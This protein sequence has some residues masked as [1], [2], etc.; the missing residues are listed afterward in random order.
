MK[1]IRNVNGGASYEVNTLGLEVGDLHK[2]LLSY[3]NEMHEARATGNSQTIDHLEAFV[4]T[5]LDEFAAT[6]CNYTQNPR[7]LENKMRGGWNLARGNVEAAL[8]AE[9]TG[10]YYANTEK[11]ASDE[12]ETA[13]KRRQSVSASNIADQLWRLGRAKEGLS[14]AQLSVKLWS[15]N[16][17]NYLVLGITAYYAGYK[18]QANH[19]F[20]SLG[21]IADFKDE[22]DMVSKCM[23]FERELRTMT[24]LPAVK[25]IVEKMGG[26]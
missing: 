16:S 23:Q 1:E 26:E 3:F 4:P 15:S 12:D 17:I 13:T 18:N 20:S 10:Y 2:R 8:E 22:R 14:W 6:E 5:L 25:N 19:I 7:W 9:L 11:I 24:D 21:Q